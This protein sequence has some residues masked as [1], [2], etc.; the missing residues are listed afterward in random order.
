MY[1]ISCKIDKDWKW[2]P[3][4]RLYGRTLNTAYYMGHVKGMSP[5][6]YVIEYAK[7][8]KKCNGW[9]GVRVIKN[10]QRIYEEAD[11]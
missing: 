6:Q 8:K 3:V 10:G 4:I 9:E 1:T 11:V 7:D 5:D 2:K